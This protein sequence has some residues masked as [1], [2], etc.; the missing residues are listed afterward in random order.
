MLFIWFFNCSVFE[1]RVKINNT[2]K[3]KNTQT[4]C[5]SRARSHTIQSERKNENGRN[6]FVDKRNGQFICFPILIRTQSEQTH[7]HLSDCCPCASFCFC[8]SFGNIWTFVCD[9]SYNTD[10]LL[11]YQLV[12]CIREYNNTTLT[13]TQALFPSFF[14]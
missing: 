3:K 2:K 5:V 1:A 8:I 4:N 11:Y 12:W 10:L 9:D 14:R 13:L 7:R 6:F